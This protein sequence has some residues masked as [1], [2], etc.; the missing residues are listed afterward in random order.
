MI[1]LDGFQARKVGGAIVGS[2]FMRRYGIICLGL[3]L[4]CSVP[5]AAQLQL[6]GLQM[7]LGGDLD[8]YYNGALSA[9]GGSSHSLS[10]GGSADLH[11]FY[12]APGFL[13]FDVTPYYGRSQA[14][15]GTL[16]LDHSGGYNAT[17][18]IFSGSHTPGSVSYNQNFD[19]TGVFGIPGVA[20]LTTENNTRSFAI[21]WGLLFPDKPSLSIGYSSGATTSSL[22]GSSGQSQGKTHTFTLGTGYRLRGFTLNA[23][24]LH[25]GSNSNASGFLVGK[26]GSTSSSTTS[27]IVG[28]GHAIPLGGSVHVTASR[29]SYSTQSVVGSETGTNDDID[30]S[31]GVT[32]WKLPVSGGVSY[33]D[34]LYG[35]VEEQLL[36][37]GDT[38]LQ[39]SSLPTSRSLSMSAGTSYTLFRR[40]FVTAFINRQ[41]QYQSGQSY[42]VTQYGANAAYNFGRRIKGLTLSA[43]VTDAA[44]KSGNGGIALQASANYNQNFRGWDF[45]GNYSYNQSVQTLLAIYTTS[46]MSYIAQIRRKFR[47]GVTLS[48]GGGGGHSG[49]EQ[50]AGSGS[51]SEGANASVTWHRVSMASH[52]SQSNG[53][54]V[55]TNSGLVAEPLPIASANTLVVFNGKSKGVSL[56]VS[57][58]R[59][60]LIDGA[61]NISTGNTLGGTVNSMNKTVLLDGYMTYQLRKLNV[62]AGVQKFR[63]S[64]TGLGGAESV[65][66]TY[67]VGI[68]RWFNFF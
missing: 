26:A 59:G 21:G 36:A 68:S 63:Q 37:N 16:S 3:L 42:G 49:F 64:A 48:F 15:S 31:V 33:S 4:L 22:L 52:Y 39:T 32:L 35:S 60:L 65:Y 12:F 67:Y 18:S 47:N 24:Y 44:S 34:N 20:G 17:A 6:G 9:T 5:A 25:M 19:S 66:T 46:S 62:N 11:G 61:Y 13:S 8:T 14:N 41:N 10:V 51:K 54:S 7:G 57:P 45:S 43:G 50:V 40:I 38:L 23:D 30:G 2:E 55:L 1:R 29:S 56:A 53:T 28:M 58:I 27:Y